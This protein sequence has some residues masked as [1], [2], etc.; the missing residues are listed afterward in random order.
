LLSAKLFLNPVTTTTT[1]LDSNTVATPTVNAILGTLDKSFPKNR[2][3][4]KIV[5]Y[6]SVLIRVREA[7]D[8]PV[9]S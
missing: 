8:E 5:S 1:S 2:E 6:A 3:L 4:A 9:K 7:N